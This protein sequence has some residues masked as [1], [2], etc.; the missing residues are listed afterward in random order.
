MILILCLIVFVIVATF[1]LVCMA[2]CMY[3][4]EIKDIIYNLKNNKDIVYNLK[5]NK[6]E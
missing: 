1:A 5:N 3:I 2:I 6:G 4:D